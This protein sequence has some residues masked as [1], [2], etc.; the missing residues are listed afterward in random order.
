MVLS[1]KIFALG[2]SN[3][4]RLPRVVMEALSLCTDDPITIEVT[5]DN[6]IMLKKS[7]PKEPY[8]AIKTLF[9]GYSGG[10]KPTEMDSCEAMGSEE[11]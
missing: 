10:Y 3:A 6:E 8:P 9:A 7:V 11:I 4:V 1:T 5:G 2:N